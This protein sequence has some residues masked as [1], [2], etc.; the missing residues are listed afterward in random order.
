MS[1]DLAGASRAKRGGGQRRSDRAK[2]AKPPPEP[3]PVEVEAETKSA[4]PA[5]ARRRSPK[6]KTERR[7]RSK[8]APG[9]SGEL[10][11]RERA[12]AIAAESYGVA[13][14]APM[15]RQERQLAR[16]R[17]WAQI[18]AE[19]PDATYAKLLALAKH[20]G[21]Q[22]AA[23]IALIEAAEIPESATP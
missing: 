11:A 23:L 15:T 21:S 1:M 7:S 2:F 4:K 19:V 10:S 14:S 22:K 17:T 8:T 16:R 12:Q 18:N 20:H 3:E 5:T 13:P 6:K 9:S